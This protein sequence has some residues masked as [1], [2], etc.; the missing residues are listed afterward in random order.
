M[1][2]KPGRSSMLSGIELSLIIPAYNEESRLPRMLDEAQHY[3]QRQY[4][5]AHEI[6]VVDDGSRDRTYDTAVKAVGA[7]RVL[8]MDRNS[9][10]G[11]AVRRG[12]LAA[13]GRL[14]LYADA[15]GA[16]PIADESRLRA[17]IDRGAD[18]A[19]GSRAADSRVRIGLRRQAGFRPP[20]GAAD[21]TVHALPHRFLMGRVF[22]A[23]VRAVL[24]L[25]FKDTQCGFK[26]FRDEAALAV[27]SETVIDGFAFDVEVVYKA[28]LLGLRVEEVPVNW[29]DVRG[30]KVSL[31]IDPW[32]MLWDIA[33]IRAQRRPRSTK[34]TGPRRAA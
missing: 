25:S 4:P 14:R 27:F 3:L 29:H 12:M 28:H 13:T 31:A 23:F 8:R 26:M 24:G 21:A 22:T 19:I 18:I 17:A 16:T 2:S 15:D 10:K 20:N 1:P 30:G 6:L 32:L 5:G 9:G 11:A 33:R 7:E 34:Q